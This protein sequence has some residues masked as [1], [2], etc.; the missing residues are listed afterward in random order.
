MALSGAAIDGLVFTSIDGLVFTSMRS[1]SLR[2]ALM[3]LNLTMGDTVQFS[4]RVDD[5][6]ESTTTD[7]LAAAP[8]AELVEAALISRKRAEASARETL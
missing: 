5:D 4:C 7:D 8:L 2:A 6:D 1:K 3:A